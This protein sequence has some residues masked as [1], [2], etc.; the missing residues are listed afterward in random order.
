MGRCAY[1]P[2]IAMAPW[3]CGQPR[4]IPGSAVLQ[5]EGP[6]SDPFDDLQTWY[7]TSGYT[8]HKIDSFTL[9]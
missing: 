3:Y 8:G 2:G 9:P 4:G 1:H 6:V 7:K 5:E